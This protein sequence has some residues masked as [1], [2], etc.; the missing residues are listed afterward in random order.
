MARQSNAVRQSEMPASMRLSSGL[1]D[2][3]VS[4]PS[5]F[6]RICELIELLFP[7]QYRHFTN[8]GNFSAIQPGQNSELRERLLRRN[9]AQDDSKNTR[10]INFID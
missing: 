7:K 9:F 6:E 10:K 8:H 4:S 2:A 1:A 5:F 3:E